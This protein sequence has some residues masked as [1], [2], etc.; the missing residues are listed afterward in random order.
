MTDHKNV[1][2]SLAGILKGYDTDKLYFLLY[3]IH[4]TII[5]CKLL[6]IHVEFASCIFWDAGNLAQFESKPRD[7][8]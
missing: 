2:S 8:V 1:I 4:W 6:E 3:F 7:E 5:F